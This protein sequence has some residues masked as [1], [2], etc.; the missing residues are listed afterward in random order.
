MTEQP[1]VITI[2]H[3]IGSGGAYVGQK[4]A[5]KLSAPF[6]DREILR[7]TAARVH[8]GEHELEGREQRLTPL[9]QS[10][11]WAAQRLDPAQSVLDDQ[12][13]P[14]DAELFQFEAEYIARI[15]EKNSAIF[16]GR[17]GFYIL[18]RHPR[19]FRL[20]VHAERPARVKRLGEMYGWSAAQAE[21]M[22]DLND[23]ERGAYILNFTRQNWLD[24]R[25]YD[26][27]VNTTLVGLD[28]TVDLVLGCAT[29]KR[30]GPAT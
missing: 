14:T 22:I 26:L 20:F 8:M 19:H 28:C 18:R 17:C 30:F 10:F 21:K 3:Q 11:A 5:E 9:W 29:D 12:Y 2:G 27:C 15:A 13:V 7:S 24:P 1:W 4:L 6:L 23:R 16:L 25:Q